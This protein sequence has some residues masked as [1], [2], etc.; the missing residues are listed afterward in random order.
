M[1]SREKNQRRGLYQAMGVKQDHSFVPVQRNAKQDHTGTD[2]RSGH[3][4][5]RKPAVPP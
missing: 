3:V 4:Q 2:G 5:A 1:S